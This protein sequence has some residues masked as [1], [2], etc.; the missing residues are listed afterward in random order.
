MDLYKKYSVTIHGEDHAKA[1]DI[2]TKHWFAG[3]IDDIGGTRQKNSD[4]GITI[5]YWIA[6]Y[7]YEDF[8]SI[9]NEFK[10]NGI[11]VL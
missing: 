3:D 10:E 2:L 8:E 11:Q 4:G 6:P 1:D 7:V 5:T 9:V